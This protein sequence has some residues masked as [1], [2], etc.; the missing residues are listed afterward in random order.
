MKKAA[1][2][3]ILGAV[4]FA[5]FFGAL[6]VDRNLHPRQDSPRPVYGATP[7]S[8]AQ[9][10]VDFREASERSTR[11]VVS[12]DRMNTVRRFYGEPGEVMPTAGGS[13][14]IFSKDGVIVTNN[15]VVQGAEQV[16]VRTA[17]GRTFTADVVGTD[18]R[19]DL[20][21]LRVKA[22]DLVPIELSHEEA[23]VG[24][25]VIAIG[26]P[27]GL[28]STV[29]V[30][31]VS[32]LGRNVTPRNSVLVD[33]IQTD[34]A[35]NPGNSGGALT[36]AQG[37]LIG[38]NTAI[39]SPTGGNVGIGFAVP[40]K[41]VSRIVEQI[42]DT[43]KASYGGLNVEYLGDVHA[44]KDPRLRAQV[45]EQ[46]GAEPPREGILVTRVIPSGAADRAGVQP[47]DVILSIEGK[48]L[49][50]ASDLAKVMNAKRP[51]EAVKIKVW[52]RGE[53]KEIRV[54]LDEL[55]I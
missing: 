38:I 44:L 17:D 33:M 40:I 20:A 48:K 6:Q 35:I 9:A 47:A 46:A 13:G 49:A 50:D 45:A 54:V 39:Q 42:L 37:R 12:I 31:V 11:S 24:E 29:S 1:S 4:C 43:G 3:L 5:G 14:V 15:H 32:G 25:W 23:R 16:Q 51:G 19:S 2:Y 21:V 36:D 27:F 28:D 8:T 30:G 55:K 22:K 10:P 7:I 53:T 26:N 52:S 18:P 41:T 34:A